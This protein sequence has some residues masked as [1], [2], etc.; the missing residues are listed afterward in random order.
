ML[1]SCP[2]KQ[3]SPGSVQAVS[4][5]P[6]LS[7][8]QKDCALVFVKQEEGEE[9]EKVENCKLENY[10]YYKNNYPSCWFIFNLLLVFGLTM[11]SKKALFYL[12]RLQVYEPK[13]FHL[14]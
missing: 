14:K 7:L 12:S 6:N 11:H 5:P 3:S 2:V 13:V 8:I 10:Y 1:C 4:G 9:E